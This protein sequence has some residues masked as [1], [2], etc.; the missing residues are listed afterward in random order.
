MSTCLKIIF[1]VSGYRISMMTLHAS[2]ASREIGVNIMVPWSPKIC[3]FG[4][5]FF[6]A[7]KTKQ[8]ERCLLYGIILIYIY[9]LKAYLLLF[10][11]TYH[12]LCRVSGVAFKTTLNYIPSCEKCLFSNKN[13]V[14][15]LY[16]LSCTKIIVNT[17]IVLYLIT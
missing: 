2:L 14:K 8:P 16:C 10:L 17:D 7:S 9:H 12:M 3:N 1:K 13:L 5:K 15:G 11:M 4:H 6:R